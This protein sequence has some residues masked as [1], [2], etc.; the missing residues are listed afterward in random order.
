M[1]G[2]LRGIPISIHKGSVVLEVG[3]VGYEVRGIE[4]DICSLSEG[5]TVLM[6]I[7]F[8]T[9]PEKTE[10]FGFLNKSDKELFS[11]INNISGV[12]PKIALVLLGATGK[13]ALSDAITQN[14][15]AIL[16]KLPGIGKKTAAK[17]ILELKER[18][19]I[20]SMLGGSTGTRATD[21][22]SALTNMGIRISEASE[23][24]RSVC[25]QHP[26]INEEEAILKALSMCGP[27]EVVR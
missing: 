15:P 14:E 17:I 10:L 9:K 23:I 21:I 4:D 11:I 12:G 19:D 2:S 27:K 16:A 3:G 25:A 22:I 1:I 6:H 24:A 18:S 7:F 13:Q 5:K 8:S 26:E 20:L